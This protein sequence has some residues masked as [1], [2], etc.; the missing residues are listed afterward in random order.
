MSEKIFKFL[1]S[2]KLTVV[3]LVCAL[4]LVFVGTL[5]QVNDGLYDAQARYFRSLF[6]FW[7]P[8]GGE[9]GIPVFPGGY[10]LGRQ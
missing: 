6:V 7:H 4:I 5:A 10:L 1:S 8:G 9:L 2:L 3:C